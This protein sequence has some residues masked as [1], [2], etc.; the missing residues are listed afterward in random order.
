MNV[1]V[2]ESVDGQK[3]A[4]LTTGVCESAC[5]FVRMSVC[6]ARWPLLSPYLSPIAVV[7][8]LVHI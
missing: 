1:S 4:R 6:V 5:L 2:C 3:Y 8:K 7:A